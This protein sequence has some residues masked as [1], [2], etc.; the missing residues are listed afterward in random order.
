M[1]L[2]GT[3]VLLLRIKYQS[4]FYLN[5]C[6]LSTDMLDGPESNDGHFQLSLAAL[7]SALFLM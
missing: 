1:T 7:L 6:A 4:S 5:E 2:E 3:S